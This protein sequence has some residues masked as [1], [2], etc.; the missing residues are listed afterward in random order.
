MIG[1]IFRIFVGAIIATVSYTC[2]HTDGYSEA[3]KD[4]VGSLRK[5]K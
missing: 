3:I 5:E 4:L 1:W 2:G